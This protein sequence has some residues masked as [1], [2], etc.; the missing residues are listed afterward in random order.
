MERRKQRKA[1]NTFI[2]QKIQKSKN[3]ELV[4]WKEKSKSQ[5]YLKKNGISTQHKK[6]G[7]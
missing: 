1:I 2:K 6:I 4:L 3:Q 5:A 7:N